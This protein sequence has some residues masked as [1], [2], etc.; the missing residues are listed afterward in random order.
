M[1]G[2][3]IDSLSSGRFSFL[4]SPLSFSPEMNHETPA[5]QE[6]GKVTL[7]NQD[8]QEDQYEEEEY[9]DYEDKE[10]EYEDV[11]EEYEEF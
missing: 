7:S 10:K 8:I 3:Q 5:G 1:L 9:K 2:L 4:A 11:E 6:G